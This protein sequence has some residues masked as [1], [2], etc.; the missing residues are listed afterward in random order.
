[1]GPPA[2]VCVEEERVWAAAVVRWEATAAILFMCHGDVWIEG[3]L[4]CCRVA[5]MLY[6]S[7]FVGG[8]QC[9]ECL[10]N[11]RMKTKIF[12]EDGDEQE[13]QEQQTEESLYNLQD[14]TKLP[15][16]QLLYKQQLNRVGSP[17]L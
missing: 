14:L 13:D 8:W 11:C 1:V 3:W 16:Y 6:N 17:Y 15:I 5:L 2:W 7:R 12:N 9:S 10:M 4:G